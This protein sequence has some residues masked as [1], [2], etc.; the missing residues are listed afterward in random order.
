MIDYSEQNGLLLQRRWPGLLDAIASAA[1]PQDIELVTGT[2]ARTLAI[3]GSLLTSSRDRIKEARLQAS[4]VPDG[5]VEVWVYG[6]AL[7]DIQRVLLQRPELHTLHVVIIDRSVARVSLVCF[8]H[9]DWLSDERLRLELWGSEVEPRQP[10]SSPPGSLRF[11]DPQCA[12]LRDK[13]LLELAAPFQREHFDNLGRVLDQQLQQNMRFLESDHDVR[14]LFGTNKGRTAIVVAGGP[15]LMGQ[16]QWIRDNRQ[17]K[18]LITVNTSLIPLQLEG[19]EPDIAVLID[20]TPGVIR[21]VAEADQQRIKNLP[22]VYFP[23]I[24]P[25]V[26]AAWPGPRYAAYTYKRRYVNLNRRLQRGFLFDSGTVTHPSVDLAVKTGSSEVIIIGADFSYPG[27]KSHAETSLFYED[28]GGPEKYRQWVV[29]GR[30]RQVQTDVNLLGY[31]RDLELYFED[32][33]EVRFLKRG[34]DGASMRG[35]PWMSDDE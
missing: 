18:L 5:S 8:D 25:D 3:N 26:V 24:H 1:P 21:H 29:S 10:F 6:F 16:Y 19:I 32:H 28:M 23:T 35:A 7:G 22:L 15:S 9:T 34:R 30:G 31:Y 11:S 13:I 12:L 17:G 4:M 20:Y 33:P 2:P 14:E 27:G